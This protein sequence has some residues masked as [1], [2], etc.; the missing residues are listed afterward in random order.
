[1]SASA[2]LRSNFTLNWVVLLLLFPFG[3]NASAG[4]ENSEEEFFT[5]DLFIMVVK[6][7]NPGVSGND[8]F[9]IPTN[10]D[11][12]YSY[13]VDWNYDG[14]S[15]NPTETPKG[16]ATHQYPGDGLYTI[17]I[18]GDF[19]QIFFNDD[20]T[21][22]TRQSDAQKLVDIVQW[23]DITWLDMS[24]SFS[25]CVNLSGTATNNPNLEEVDNM[26]A[27]FRGCSNLTMDMSDWD[28]D[29]VKNFKAVFQEASMFN[30]DISNWNV[31]NGEDFSNMFLDASSFD[32]NLGSWNLGSANNLMDFLSDSGLSQSAYDMTLSGWESQN[33]PPG[34]TVGVNNLNY[35]QSEISRK[36]LIDSLGWTF[37]GDTKDCP[38]VMV[39]KTD[40]YGEFTSDTEY[41]IPTSLSASDIYNYDV[42][43][44]Y[45]GVTFNA[46]DTNVT[47]TITHDYGTPGTYTIAIRGQFPQLYSNAAGPKA[48]PQKILAINQWG[49]IEWKSMLASFT[50]C[51]NLVIN[52][53]DLPDLTEVTSYNNAFRGCASLSTIP[54]MR[55][56]DV[57]N[58]QS[59][60]YMFTATTNFNQDISTWDVSSAIYLNYM[61]YLSEAFNQDLGDWDVSNVED[62]SSM[63]RGAM[64]FNQ[65]LSQWDVSSGEEFDDMFR[66]ATAFNQPLDTWD[67]S[68]ATDIN[69]MLRNC[70]M[71]TDNYDATLIGWAN[72]GV[73]DGLVLGA[74]NLEYCNGEMARNTLL[75]TYNWTINGDQLECGNPGGNCP[76]ARTVMQVDIATGITL[77][78]GESLET[79][80]TVIIAPGDDV[81]FTAGT[82]ITLNPGFSAQGPFTAR[83]EACA[84]NS[85]TDDLAAGIEFPGVAIDLPSGKTQPDL[86]LEVFPNPANGPMTFRFEVSEVGPVS[87]HVFTLKGELIKTLLQDQIVDPGTLDVNWSDPAL[88]SGMYLAQLQTDQGMKTAKVIVRNF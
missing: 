57:S 9:T 41:R 50:G 2:N 59:F 52:A 66:D 24:F 64:V 32:Q 86:T 22:P 35:C 39:I 33:L 11:Y 48:D 26:E 29:N 53:P 78:A 88:P 23:G 37:N 12:D 7:I 58:G 27:A 74:S 40:N 55:Y 4:V 10:P 28:V 19:P 69:R 60:L 77:S 72:T 25:G 17:A 43:W 47:D 49:S 51:S 44:T 42:D 83:I 21:S 63:F 65:D 70:G 34:L 30:S 84:G 75:T 67:L 18:R 68:S 20:H 61:F 71:D 15:F 73:P 6:T 38:F 80:G 56:W 62:F 31:G 16:D 45:D 8:E 13:E 5:D 46:D 81:T 87:L 76:D 85:S 54:S 79:S 1:M 14:N 3:M 82:T 36:S